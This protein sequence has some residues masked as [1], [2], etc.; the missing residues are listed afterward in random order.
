MW[1]RIIVLALVVVA[2]C[3][4]PGPQ[5][6]P[7]P[8]PDRLVFK[9]ITK[10]RTYDDC[11][12]GADG[13]SY[14]RLD[15]PVPVAAPSGFAVEAVTE[16]VFS[17]VRAD[18]NEG[19]YPTVEALMEDFIDS[20]RAVQE[21]DPD[22]DQTWFL[23][24]KVF[25][26]HNTPDIVSWS[27]L[28][29]R[30]EGGERSPET[31]TFS[32]LDPQTGETIELSDVL[33]EGYEEGLLSVAEARFRKVRGIEEDVSLADAGFMSFDTGTFA[34]T[35]NVAI[36]EDGLTFYYNRN[37][38]A[39]YDMGATEITLSYRELGDVLKEDLPWID[40]NG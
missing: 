20:Y 13:C 1:S 3:T 9:M 22:Y 32:N 11:I 29:R 30:Y 7:P 16:A 26:L 28:E 27:L 24:R 37:E 14:V 8:E 39:P 21:D 19:S 12:A 15:F 35:E 36:G 5:E 18:G 25:V 40:V 33:V 4:P 38:I 17:Q 34:L 6:E 2:G 23:E 31:I 10:E